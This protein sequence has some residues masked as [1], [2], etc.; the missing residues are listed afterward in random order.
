MEHNYRIL[1][2]TGIPMLDDDLRSVTQFDIIGCCNLKSD[3]ANMADGLRPDILLVSDHISGEEN[4]AQTI[5]AVK[6]AHPAIR[7]I[8]FAGELSARDNKR[9]DMLGML[10]MVGIYDIVI[11]KT[12]NKDIAVDA[13]IH[14]RAYDAVSYLTRNLID[15]RAEVYNAFG[16]LQY[17][18][19]ELTDEHDKDNNIYVFTSIK[20]G[21]GKSFASINTACAIAKYGV[22]RPKVAL[23]DADLQT[24][25]VGTALGMEDDPR[26]NIQTCMETI[27]GIFE[28]GKVIEDVEKVKRAKRVMKDCF[29]RYPKIPNL[30][31]LIGSSL[32]PQEID[33]LKI[34][35]EYYNYLVETIRNEYDIVIVDLNSNIFH[36]TTFGI[37]RLCKTAYYIINL[38]FN[39]IRNNV[40][41]K[42]MLSEIDIS[43]KVKYVLNQAIE[44]TDAY[45]YLG[46]VD[47]PLVFTPD[48]M[49]K[50]SNIEIFKKLPFISPVIAYNNAFNGLPAIL[51]NSDE[52]DMA[53]FAIMDLAN[54]IHPM[55]SEYEKLKRILNP[56][57][58]GN[59]FSNLFAKK[60]GTKKAKKTSKKDKRKEVDVF[61]EGET[62]A[63]T[64]E[65]KLKALYKDIYEE[66]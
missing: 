48:D 64:E 9:R 6:N 4:L 20:P 54:D 30:E 17:E 66:K 46:V 49:E 28:N 1:S 14:P 25:S 2:A 34:R 11:G 13:I 56:E 55:G 10:V 18:A 39:N 16:G 52:M 50:K 59:F 33:A 29:V 7:I 57:R 41:Y 60:E 12:L 5:L 35:P 44:N 23:I 31:V 26:K 45:E 32:T 63:P 61:E 37:L 58:N 3:I 24:L 8:Y 47:R 38:D 40:R 42:N 65:D 27:A 19:A 53:R 43:K 62:K 21:T 36:V 51:D 22:D 15:D